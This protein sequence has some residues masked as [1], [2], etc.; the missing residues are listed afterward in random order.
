VRPYWCSY[1]GLFLNEASTAPPVPLVIASSAE[2]IDRAGQDSP[3]G[4]R[5]SWISP[6][7][8]EHLTLSEAARIVDQRDRAFEQSRIRNQAAGDQQTGLLPEM[9]D[10]TELIVGGLRGPVVPIAVGGSLV[11]LLLVAGAGS[12]WVDRRIRE[13]RLLSSRGVGPLPLAVKAGLELFIPAAA[14]TVLGWLLARWL[15]GALGPSPDV[16]AAAPWQAALTAAAGP[17]ACWPAWHCSGWSPGSDLA[18]PANA[19]SAPA[20]PGLLGC[21]GSWHS[22]AGSLA[23]WL[24]GWCCSAPAG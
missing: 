18:Q 5:R 11:A 22:S 4:V 23:S 3:Y 16:D 1:T 13:V 9:V 7:Q 24:A 17:L 20:G 8:T 21:R 14:G 19:R 10:R 15:I 2:L 12:Y 6:I